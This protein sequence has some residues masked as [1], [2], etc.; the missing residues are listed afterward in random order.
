[1][2]S[3]KRGGLSQREYDR[4]NGTVLKSTKSSV[5]STKEAKK[6]A[7]S[8]VSKESKSLAAAQKEY[9]SSLNPSGEEVA[10]TSQLGQINQGSELEAKK[11][12]ESSHCLT[13]YRP[14]N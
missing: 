11:N 8:S 6:S 10:A 9:L 14:P 12:P 5:M 13:F 7:S 3:K 1:M 2:P 4:K